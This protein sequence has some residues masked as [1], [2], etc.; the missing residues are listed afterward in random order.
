MI[1]AE[2]GRR[3]GKTTGSLAPKIILAAILCAGLPGEVL[4]PTYR[5]SM[6]VWR[7]VLKLSPHAWWI[8]KHKTDRVLTLANGSTVRLLSADREDSARSEGV[9]WGAYDERQD[10]SEEAAANAFLSTSEGGE[11]F[12][13]F[14]TATIKP[15]LE[16]H[17]E[18]VEASSKGKI[19]SMDSY[20]NPFTNHT[21]LDDASEFLD[22][23]TIEREI[24]GRWPKLKG[25]IYPQFAK[26]DHVRPY[27]VVYLHAPEPATAAVLFDKYNYRTED[28]DPFLVSVDPPHSAVLWKFYAD[29]TMHAV[30]EVVVGLEGTDK[31]DGGVEILAQLCAQR[32]GPALGVVIIDPHET[33]YDHDCRVYFGQQRFR[34][35]AVP[36]MLQEYKLTAVRARLEKR[37]LLVS[38][39]CKFYAEVLGKHKRDENTNR[40]DKRQT[41]KGKK[42]QLVHLGDAGAYGVYKH[43]PP[44]RKDDWEKL[45]KKA[46]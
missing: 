42:I 30:D 27:P 12:Q 36:R 33:E 22:E 35:A 9:A 6:N 10:I 13:I 37:K 43:F 5:Q 26:D 45:E 11:D 3:S 19:Y 15:E 32:T 46:A 21:F 31:I 18:K 44:P 2:G 14:E 34:I 25:R 29:G 40:P 39:R 4:S 38:P 23:D 20:G 7:A 16:E 28:G 8:G 24:R 1:L 17:H 41:Y